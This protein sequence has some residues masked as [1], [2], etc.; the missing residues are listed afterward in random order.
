MHGVSQGLAQ[1][2]MDVGNGPRR[3]RPAI[4]AAVLGQLPVEL[5]DHGWSQCLQPHPADAGH[6]VVINI[7]AVAC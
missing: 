5:G 2:A 1:G 3:Q 4:T 6:D 7:V